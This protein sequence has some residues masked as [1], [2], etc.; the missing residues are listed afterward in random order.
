[1]Q[2]FAIRDLRDHTAELVRNAENGE[3]S[4]VS[5]HGKPIFVALPFDSQLLKSGV[6]VALA[7]KLVQSGELSTGAAAKLASMS[8]DQYLIHL[9]GLGVSMF[10]E[11]HWDEELALLMHKVKQKKTVVKE[12]TKRLKIKSNPTT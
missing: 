8:Y 9:G 5:K 11:G 4:I 7:D 6:N 12:P 10:T 3:C 2:S 1:M